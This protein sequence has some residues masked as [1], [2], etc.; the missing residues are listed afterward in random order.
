MAA[1]ESRP[2]AVDITERA[3]VDAEARTPHHLGDHRRNGARATIVEQSLHER[4][5]R[6]VWCVV[7]DSDDPA[8]SGVDMSPTCTLL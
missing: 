2:A 6:I 3:V 1:S 8:P 4:G 7:G 5:T